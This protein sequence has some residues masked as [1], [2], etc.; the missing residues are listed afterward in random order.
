S[1]TENPPE[2]NR[3]MPGSDLRK[4]IANQGWRYSEYKHFGLELEVLPGLLHI[5]ELGGRIVSAPTI[6]SPTEPAEIQ[7]RFRRLATVWKSRSRYLSNPAQAAMLPEYQH[8]IGMGFAAVP[9]ILEEL[10][11]EPA[12]WFWALTA[13]TEENPV[14]AESAGNTEQ[15][16]Q[17]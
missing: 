6:P 16:A 7:D 17:S 4:R 3:P 13:I 2:K 1:P 10:R 9:L 12:Q 11:Q 5:R 15:M 8:I 14:P